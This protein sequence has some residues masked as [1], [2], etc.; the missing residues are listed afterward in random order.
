MQM[1]GRRHLVADVASGTA[2]FEGS[3]SDCKDWTE[4]AGVYST[5]AILTPYEIVTYSTKK[6]VLRERITASAESKK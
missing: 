6:V 1:T 2:C 4:R 3:L 5:F